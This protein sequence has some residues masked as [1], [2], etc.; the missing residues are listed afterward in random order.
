MFKTCLMNRHISN[1]YKRNTKYSEH[2]I[3][4][5]MYRPRTIFKWPY[6]ALRHVSKDTKTEYEFVDELHVGGPER[7]SRIYYT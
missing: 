3:I 1:I 2:I 7:D 5:I 6:P 4:I